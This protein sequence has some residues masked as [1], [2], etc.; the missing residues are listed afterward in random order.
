M[1]SSTVPT[2]VWTKLLGSDS[3]EAVNALTTGTDGAI[4]I[5]GSTGG[6]FN[7]QVNSGEVDAYIAKYK[8]DGTNVWTRFI[9]F[10]SWTEANALAAGS[11]G[12]LYVTGNT[13]GAFEGRMTDGTSAVFLTQFDAGGFQG[14]T[15]FLL[16][17]SG[18]VFG[19]ALTIGTNDVV[20]VSGFADGDLEGQTHDG[21]FSAFLTK[22]SPDGTREWIELLNP[23]TGSGEYALA[24]GTY[25]RLY[26]FNEGGSVLS[27]E[28]FFW[29]SDVIPRAL[30]FGSDGEVYLAG[31]SS[32]SPVGSTAFLS[33]YDVEGVEIWT[34]T[35]GLSVSDAATALAVSTDGS[36]YIAG[37]T[38]PEHDRLKE[39][40]G[41]NVFIAKYDSDGT[42]IWTKIFG[43]IF[44]ESV[45]GIATGDDGEIYVA[46]TTQGSFDGQINNVFNSPYDS[47][48]TR[49]N[50]DGTRAWTRFLGPSSGDL[51]GY[52][53]IGLDGAI[54]MAG[55]TDSDLDEE[56]NNGGSD[57][58]LSK[59]TLTGADLPELSFSTSSSVAIEGNVGNSTVTIE[60]AL[61]VSSTQAVEVPITYLGTASS[62]NDYTNA[63]TSIRI[64]AGQLVGSLS[65]TVIGDSIVEPDEQVILTMGT[66]INANLGTN[67]S[68]TYVI[69]NDDATVTTPVSGGNGHWY[70][71][72]KGQLS[73]ASALFSATQS[74][75]RGL[76][77]Y[78]AT[79]SSKGENQIIT[80]ILAPG[81]EGYWLGG[82]KAPDNLWY[83]QSG[84]ES[85][86][87]FSYGYS[88]FA[89]GE[90]N[91][92][93]AEVYLEIWGPSRGTGEKTGFWNDIASPHSSVGGYIIEYGSLAATYTITPSAAWVNESSA[94][95]FTIDTKNIEWGKTV[96]Y[97][98]TG[99]S[100]SDLASGSLTGTAT[101]NQNG[102]DGRATVT[103]NLANDQ[104]TEGAE[105]LRLTVESTTSSAVTV[106]DTSMGTIASLTSAAGD[107]VN[108][109]INQ[110]SVSGTSTGTYNVSPT[111]FRYLSNGTPETIQLRDEGTYTFEIVQDGRWNN[112]GSYLTATGNVTHKDGTQKPILGRFNS[113]MG[114]IL[115]SD[116]SFDFSSKDLVTN[117]FDQF[118]AVGQFA[119]GNWANLG[120]KFTFSVTKDASSYSIVPSSTSVNEGSAVT[121]TIDTKSVKWGTEISYTLTGISQSDLASGLLTGT[122]TVNQNGVDGRATVTVNLANDQ[123]TEGAESLRLMVASTVSSDVLVNDTS[124]SADRTGRTKYFV[125]QN[126]GG[127]F[128]DFD[129][130]HPGVTLQNELIEFIGSAGVDTAFVRPGVVLDFTFSGAGSD[131]AYLPGAFA[132][133]STSLAGNTMTLQ[134]GSGSTLEKVSVVAATSAQASDQ[135]VFS[136]G[137]VNSYALYGHMLGQ[138]AAPVPNSSETSNAPLPPAQPGSPLN[139]TIKAF[140]LNPDGDTFA[141]MKPGVALMAHGGIG[142]DKV[143]VADASVVDA[144]LLGASADQIYLRGFWSEY[145]KTVAGTTIVLTRALDTIT[146]GVTVAAGEFAL[147][148]TLIFADG[149]VSSLAARAALGTNPAVALQAIAGF[150]AN[151]KTPG[152]GPSLVQ[153]ALDDVSNLDPTSNIVLN[154]TM[155]VT[156][157][158][159]K[160]IRIVNDA[161]S[162]TAATGFRGESANNT[163]VIAA[164][165]AS[166]VSISG[167]RVTINPTADLD[168]ANRYHIEIDEGAF[169]AP[170]S[171]GSRAV[172]AASGLNFATVTPGS[173]DLSVAAASQTMT[174]DGVLAPSAKWLDIEGIGSQPSN[175]VMMDLGAASY[176]LVFKDYASKPA[177]PADGYSGVDAPTFFIAANNFGADDRIYIDNQSSVAN[178]LSVERFL[179][180]GA[181]PTRIQFAPSTTPASLGG[182]L[183]VTLVGSTQP[184]TSIND[185]M[186]KL[187]ST[188][189]PMISG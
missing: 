122:A 142:V 42:K 45:S 81:P 132:D 14:W 76:H 20:Y 103:V 15:R 79:V 7:G 188:V 48:V 70:A 63:T 11:D 58:F 140:G 154:F 85:E 113:Y 1:T 26:N 125:T 156:A 73:F 44:D 104:A 32:L 152:V 121:F 54:F 115:F 97:T 9:G 137:V 59:L 148:D 135:L 5:A 109:S 177:V 99:I 31:A 80:S 78:L 39:E 12:K 129:L 51:G 143:Y 107:G 57:A 163:L 19:T 131:K 136:D 150:D 82:K 101:V 179:S 139:A 72:A 110:V 105:S 111:F 49:I 182:Y 52:L 106:N 128:T 95:T 3:W 43:S 64:P 30:T 123:T 124:V 40:N 181:A 144:T 56:I 178:D 146:E 171:V 10:G 27:D 33:K 127:N 133:Y 187:P 16:S 169:I 165:D 180:T 83:W 119:P 71:L 92:G 23:T 108:Y 116:G 162:A 174:Q 94:V 100:Q 69:A 170:N 167:S 75:Y 120:R 84:P 141:M 87:Q 189:P 158:A 17:S 86:M 153:S 175:R 151:L 35:L 50:P 62:G 55:H 96:S 37:T 88:N 176:V 61:N 173:Y 29:T 126:A 53:T 157:S 4:Y 13:S 65:F 46:G 130:D 77:G 138:Q 6:S 161:A 112:D 90:P 93:Q 184:F 66:P 60:A 185:W 118:L 89:S 160:F 166:Q 38:P 74:S 114:G 147:N 91:G 134:H 22:F 21:G 186:A 2:K 102:V 98:L 34:Q 155:P 164:N 168:L 24:D 67:T 145:T 25:P 36:L 172:N 47:F 68:H 28:A 41:R 149:A 8:P 117:G 18:D 183:D 159:N